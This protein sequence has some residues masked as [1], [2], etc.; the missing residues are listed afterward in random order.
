MNSANISKEMVIKDIETSAIE[1]SLNNDQHQSDEW[2]LFNLIIEREQKIKSLKD[3]D[4][5]RNAQKIAVL[6]GE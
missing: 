2:K 3:E 5:K 6:L 1:T 4:S